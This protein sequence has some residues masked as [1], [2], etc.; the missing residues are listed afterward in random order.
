MSQSH[1]A[2]SVAIIGG[3]FKAILDKQPG[4]NKQHKF[5]ATVDVEVEVDWKVKLVS[6][7]P[8]GL[9]PL[10]KLLRFEVVLPTGRHSNAITRRTVRYDEVP[11]KHDYTE[12]TV[13]DGKQTESVTVETVV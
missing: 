1:V 6:A 10:D 12:A 13:E 3:T 11:A 8:E 2:P 5:Y 9:N 7:N 4:P